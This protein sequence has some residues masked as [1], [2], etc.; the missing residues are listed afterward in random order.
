MSGK[1]MQMHVHPGAAIKIAQDINA[2]EL[3]NVL[4]IN[5]PVPVTAREAIEPSEGK[6]DKVLTTLFGKQ[7][8]LYYNYDTETK[9]L[10]IESRKTLRTTSGGESIETLTDLDTYGPDP[11]FALPNITDSIIPYF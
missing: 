5:N 3:A 6:S 10:Y 4:R 9:Q 11:L 7:G 2:N 1:P 8:G